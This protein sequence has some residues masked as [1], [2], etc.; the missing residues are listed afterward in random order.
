MKLR[1][2]IST[3]LA[4][5]TAMLSAQ[6]TWSL[7]QCVDYAIQNNITVQKMALQRDNQELNLKTSKLSF[8][9]NLN[10][11]VG[12][13]F[14]FGRAT[15]NDNITTSQSMAS[16]SFG[17]SSSMPL[18]SGLRITNQIASDKLNLQ[19]A[20][21]DLN[22]AKESLTINVTGY[23]LNILYYKELLAIANNQIILSK[24]QVDNTEK[25]VKNGKKSES[26]LYENKA[27]LATDEQ[28]RT[29]AQNSLQL[30]ILNMCQAINYH[31]IT[32]FSV[33]EIDAEKLLA[34]MIGTLSS[35][36]EA[37]NTSLA[38]RP[39]IK[40]SEIRIESSKKDLK[41]A[42]SAYY[43]QLN[44]QAGYNTGYY[45]S[46]QAENSAFGKQLGDNSSEVIALSLSIPIFNRLS[47]MNKVKQARINILTQELE[48]EN[49]K[50]T[51]L[52][53]IQTA[54]YNALA[55]RDKYIAA[56]KTSESS[57]IAFEFE[58]A[59]YDG[60]K[61]TPFDFNNAKTRLEKAQAQETQAKYEFI[62]RT[63]IFDFY[64]GNDITL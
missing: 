29:E 38:V 62:F 57:R 42:E 16:T 35:P 14:S 20:V 55:A 49:A 43:P 37:Y 33:A 61:S 23:Y 7:E 31:D 39:S 64:N 6:Q 15:G 12:Q 21:E 2:I 63:K 9:P 11:N 45:H 52:K 53:E 4:A 17:V 44:L 34:S 54:Y 40:A 3:I 48:L 56:G 32:N 5:I 1:T 24:S 30:A 13:N 60:G 50:Q 36:Y 8:V 25:L 59:K 28:T 41:I 47:T 46:F 27:Q 51:L 18:F 58:Q 22:K 10:A 26:E 19:A